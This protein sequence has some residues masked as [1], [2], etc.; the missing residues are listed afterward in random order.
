[1]ESQERWN[2][3]QAF[4]P[5]KMLISGILLF[6]FSF[7]YYFVP[8]PEEAAVISAGIIILIAAFCAIIMT[9]KALRDQFD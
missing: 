8:L 9:E 7:V 5:P 4:W 3:A 6:I 2:F 1:M